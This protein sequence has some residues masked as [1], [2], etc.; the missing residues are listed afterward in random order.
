MKFAVTLFIAILIGLSGCARLQKVVRA[1]A[2]ANDNAVK[3]AIFTICRGASIGAI[4]RE[5]GKDP[6]SV[7]AWG[8]L[9]SRKGFSPFNS[10]SPKPAPSPST[11]GWQGPD[12]IPGWT[13]GARP[14]PE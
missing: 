12:R 1:G 11:Q 13:A 14:G 9:C 10:V 4:R 8:A 3:A 2:D 6:Q 5:F 7:F